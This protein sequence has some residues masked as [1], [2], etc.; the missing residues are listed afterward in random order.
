LLRRLVLHRRDDH[1]GLG[2]LRMPTYPCPL[3]TQQAFVFDAVD[4]SDVGHAGVG[5][6]R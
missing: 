2:V 6:E 5:V 4:R 3:G 1:V